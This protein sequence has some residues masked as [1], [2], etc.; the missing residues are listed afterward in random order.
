MLIP[1]GAF[2]KFD[3]TAW[4]T[5]SKKSGHDLDRG[6]DEKITDG[7]RSMFEKATG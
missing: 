4:D 7:A 3:S 5:A 2:A 6:T 1:S